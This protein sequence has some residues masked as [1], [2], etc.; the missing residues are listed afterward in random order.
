VVVLA[1]ST[2]ADRS[3]VEKAVAE[4]HDALNAGDANAI[5]GR[6][7]DEFRRA[8]TA[9]G[10]AR[11]VGK[12]QSRL[13]R[14]E[15]SR[16]ESYQFDVRVGADAGTVIQVSYASQFTL[17]SGTD[18]FLFRVRDG[19]ALLVGYDMKSDA[20]NALMRLALRSERA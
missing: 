10:F 13:G 19:R 6:A 9:D 14:F 7:D 11:A 12:I 3:L 16:E 4:F 20:L 1:C 15:R 17:A 18:I 8:V 5:Y 2:A